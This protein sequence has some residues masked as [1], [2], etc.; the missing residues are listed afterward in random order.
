MKKI[1]STVLFILFGY[2]IA[3]A[4]RYTA[5]QA[6]K[7]VSLLGVVGAFVGSGKWQAFW[8]GLAGYEIAED[9]GL[10]PYQERKGLAGLTKTKGEPNA[11]EIAGEN[12][13]YIQSAW[14]P[15]FSYNPEAPKN[16]FRSILTQYF[17]QTHRHETG[18]YCLRK[19]DNKT[20]YY[21]GIVYSDERGMERVIRHFQEDSQNTR[22]NHNPYKN[23]NN[24]E[25][26]F[27]QIENPTRER[28]ELFEWWVHEK[29][30]PLDSRPQSSA[31]KII[32]A[33]PEEQ[34]A[35]ELWQEYNFDFVITKEMKENSYFVEM[36]K[37]RAEVIQR[38]Y[39]RTGEIDQE[40][41]SNPYFV[42]F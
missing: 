35:D 32:F 26:K 5:P 25:V 15:I 19:K 13:T 37:A 31:T 24:W 12:I 34:R 38:L 3:L 11:I 27:Y 14:L 9:A 16:K 17:S 8:A 33:N 23:R 7:K 36:L 22:I 1:A 21:V 2:L 18:V 41:T 4:I 30:K 28:L 6:K 42:P 10:S 40:M 20:V 39:D 29:L